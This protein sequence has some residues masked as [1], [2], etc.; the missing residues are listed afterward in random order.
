MKPVI[1][2]ALL[3]DKMGARIPA[4]QGPETGLVQLPGRVHD[5]HELFY[6]VHHRCR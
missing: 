5:L 3:V 6:P 2:R 4:T 1:V